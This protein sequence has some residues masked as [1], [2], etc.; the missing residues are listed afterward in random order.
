MLGS[1]QLLTNRPLGEG[2]DLPPPPP[3]IPFV[4]EE[5]SAPLPEARGSG[6]KSRSDSGEDA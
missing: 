3:L 6:D 1:L 2:G 5:P 4:L